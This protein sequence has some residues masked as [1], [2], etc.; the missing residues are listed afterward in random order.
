MMSGQGVPVCRF[1]WQRF[2]GRERLLAAIFRLILIFREPF[3]DIYLLMIGA[4]ER[5]EPMMKL[6]EIE[7]GFEWFA[8]TFSSQRRP[9]PVGA[10]DLPLSRRCCRRGEASGVRAASGASCFDHG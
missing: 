4:Y 10:E 8:K 2:V 3:S 1:R 5:R 9:F 7:F 6:C